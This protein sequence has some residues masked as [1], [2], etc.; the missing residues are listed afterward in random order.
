[1]KYT[2]Y[3]IFVFVCLSS[4]FP[5]FL[6]GQDK[7]RHYVRTRLMTKDDGSSFRETIT[8]YNSFGLNDEIREIGAS[9]QG[10]DL[11]TFVGYDG[12]FRKVSESLPRPVGNTNFYN[13]SNPE[14]YTVYEHSEL[15]RVRESYGPGQTWRENG[16]SVK[17][18]YLY[19]T[20]TGDDHCYC[21]SAKDVG[22]D[23]KVEVKSYD[24]NEV[25]ILRTTDEDGNVTDQFTD[26]EGKLIL[27]RQKANGIPHDTYIVYDDHGRK[28][29][30][31]PPLAADALGG[32][33]TFMCSQVE[34]V[35]LYGYLYYY[36]ERDRCIKKKLPGCEPIYYVY[37]RCNYLV[38]KQDGNDR[39]AGRWQ[40]FQYDRLGRQVIWA[41]VT[42]NRTHADW[43]R[44]CKNQDLSVYFIGGSY[45]DNQ[46]GYTPVYRVSDFCIPLIINYYDNYEYTTIFNDFIGFLN[47]PGYYSSFSASSLTSRDKLTG[48]VVALLNDPSKR[49]YIA[50]Y[51][52]QRGREVQSTM[53]SA[54]G[55]RNYTFTNYDFTGQPVSV[56]KEHTS[57]YRDTPPASVDDVDHVMTYEYEYDHAGRLSKLYQTYD[58]DA[59][60]LVAKYEHDE[61]GRLEKKLLYNETA[62]STYKY[63]VRGWP[64]EINEPGMLE[65]I[66]YNEDLPQ[67]VTPLYNGNITCLSNSVNGDLISRFSYDSLN[68]LL[69]T[70]QYKPNGTPIETFEE[71]TYDKMGNMLTFFRAANEPQPHYINQMTVKYHG[72]QVQKVSDDSR[73]I[74]Y[75]SLRYP[76]ASNREIEYFYDDNGSLI[77]NLDNNMGQIKYNI[78]NL[79]EVIVFYGGNLLTY[80]Y[81]ADG[82][83]VRDSYGS[84]PTSSSTPLDDVINNT[85]P[86]IT[87]YN[88]WNEDYY[89]QSGILKRVTTPE[90]YFVYYSNSGYSQL[91]T[92]KD[93]VGSIWQ[94][95]G[96]GGGLTTRFH[97]YYPSGILDKK[98]NVDYPFALGGKEFMGKNNLDEYF[99]D[100][101]TMYAIMNRFNQMDPLCEKYYSVSPYAYCGNNPVNCIDPTGMDWYRNSDGDYIWRE[102]HEA[103]SGYENIGAEVSIQLGENSYLNFYQNGGIWAN[104]A[105]NAF[106]LIRLSPRL[107]N[108]FLER[109]S[110]LSTQ[111]Q[112]ELFC[113]LSSR[114]IDEIARP[115]G[116]ELVE[117][118]ASVLVAPLAGKLIGWGAEWVSSLFSKS[119]LTNYQLVQ[120][121]ATL[122]EKAIGGKGPVSGTAKHKYASRLLE[123]YQ[124][125]YGDRGLATNVRFN[126][127]VGNRGVLDVLDSANGIIY[128][129]KF[130][131]AVMRSAQYNKYFTN[132]GL[133]IQIIRP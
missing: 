46:Y 22:E 15:N 122:A 84:F 31:L 11:Q 53:N 65:K 36:D 88:D 56:R 29:V 51:Y 74:D 69:T 133:P 85:D 7:N 40:S 121:A 113:A 125:I 114:D 49:D 8:Y 106:D 68:R 108:Q 102:G 5:S 104:Q 81:M 27:T 12:A 58:N 61:V 1:M 37:D 14:S 54:F 117:V 24:A 79:P 91:Y 76:G 93:H 110:T 78:L 118:G 39:E 63:N 9:P 50:Y 109:K 128:D 107:Q 42:R 75:S 126:N 99:F 98:P 70:R 43:I 95:W 87:G 48:Q 52:D 20:K 41:F 21:L 64:T 130:G 34:A 16:K 4:F 103:I 35:Q 6:K 101:R 44:I 45:Y 32:Y 60:V 132:F 26:H 47:R 67:G 62:T 80:S 59:K 83:K 17:Y 23:I 120:K 30:V 25:S 105:A 127:G 77:T 57:I 112:K 100:A 19:N 123:R 55:F 111:S 115:I 72:N 71:F 33:S 92:S 18:T 13:D 119:G 94:H 3:S 116:E 38:L 2:L 82:R 89:Y 129:F 66:Y 124:A 86:Y 73:Y 10:N 90:G 131:K 28:R 97:S 96:K